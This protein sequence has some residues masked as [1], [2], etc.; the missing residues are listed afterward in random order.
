MWSKEEVLAVERRLM[1][2]V[3]TGK[4]PSKVQCLECIRAF[5]EALKGR[6]WDAVKYYVKNCNNT[7]KQRSTSSCLLQVVYVF[8]VGKR[9]C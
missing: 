9:G 7:W 3:K 6:T 1:C 2:S 4:V 5:P 8:Y